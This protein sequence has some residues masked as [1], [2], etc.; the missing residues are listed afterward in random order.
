MNKLGIIKAVS[1]AATAAVLA[2]SAGI[3]PVAADSILRT[4][5]NGH[6]TD[7]IAG[8]N[9][10]EYEVDSV[11]INGYATNG[12]GAF[13][14][15]RDDASQIHVWCLQADV[16]HST[17]ANYQASPLNLFTSGQLDYLTF[18]YA[19]TTDDATATAVQS[20]I[21]Y[22]VNTVRST[23]PVPVW[24]NG[25]SGFAPIAPDSPDSWA[26]LP[27]FDTLAY[28]VGLQLRGPAG[29][30]DLDG[31]ETLV[32][33]VT[34]DANL[35]QGPWS[36]SA[37][38][39]TGTPGEFRTRITS[40]WNA[41]V[42]GRTVTFTLPNGG[43]Q[44]AVTDSFGYATISGASVS[45]VL[46]VE[47]SAP[48]THVEF[49]AAGVQRV[50]GAGAPTTIR[51]NATFLHNPQL[52]STA[53]DQADGD[54][55]IVEG[56]T[57]ADSVPITQLT[58]G[59]SYTLHGQLYDT[60]T[61]AF[62]GAQVAQTFTALATAET[63]SLSTTV[64]AGAAGHKV[65]WI[66][67]LDDDTFSRSGVVP[68]TSYDD[69]NETLLVAPTLAL[70]TD[71]GPALTVPR[72]QSVDL[73][74]RV[75]LSGLAAEFRSTAPEAA[76][77]TVTLYGP[78]A[79]LAD[80]ECVTAT[81]VGS[82]PAAFQT[83]G[84][85]VSGPVTVTPVW[86]DAVYTWVATVATS[87]GRIITHACGLANES[88]QIISDVTADVHLRK[89]I[90]VDGSTWHN[91]QAGTAPAYE[92]APAPGEPASGS[93]DDQIADA[94]DGVPVLAVGAQVSFHYEV[95]L[96]P[97]ST[98]WA[99]WTDG[100]TGVVTDD[101][102]TAADIADDFMPVYVSGDDGDGFLEPGETWLYEA[103]NLLIAKAGD[104]YL[105][106]STIPAGM[107]IDPT[108]PA[109]DT[110][111]S[112]TPRKD[113]AGYVTPA[114]STTAINPVDQSHVLGTEGGTVNDTTTC[115]NLVPGVA[116]TVS[117]ELQ[118]RQPD[119]RVIA[120]GIVGS[121]TFTPAAATATTVV[122]FTVPASAAPG[123][124]VAFETL[125]IAA[126]GRVLGGHRDPT[127]ADQSIT[128]RSPT[129]VPP[130]TPAISTRSQGIPSTG[131]DAMVAVRLGSGLVG[132]GVTV[133]AL[134]RTRRRR[135]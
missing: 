93:H 7:W 16:A 66:L 26:A 105:N 102:G 80:A 62:V 110:G 65:V 33:Q 25:A 19:T 52:S 101:N 100:T 37:P 46:G 44:T 94:G 84:T 15:L 81:A 47:A 67:S 63:H 97:A 14:L 23:T 24:G 3:L 117:G 90:S 126:T 8:Y 36:I 106:Y 95:W 89:T 131:V 121:S 82:A 78:F 115:S 32:A 13:E 29:A 56:G 88:P 71:A 39:A 127:D 17:T 38:A 128:K 119:G 122:V 57:A 118:A 120:T 21:W 109:R 45:G 69:L 124:Y 1:G 73:T 53:S 64:P 112:T 40:A 61:A 92:P 9:A 30:I 72:G 2:A 134:S 104:N 60:T 35:L 86:Y 111:Q 75:T 54:Q 11:S 87:Q 51:S 129:V 125:S 99:T 49:A 55:L 48:D 4:T 96:D 42:S 34:A 50:V 130:A 77:G 10:A 18:M 107:V 116:V 83:D 132:A 41:P 85:I 123:A 114:C 133:L 43:T 98:G 58:I 79:T 59:N 108:A 103:R 76:M 113:P 28:P 6:L 12:I 91:V 135:C 22:F 70:A 5:Q 68:P 31:A 20:A 74:D 27:P